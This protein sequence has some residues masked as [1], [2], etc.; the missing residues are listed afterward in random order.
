MRGGCPKYRPEEV[1]KEPT[2]KVFSGR[3]KPRTYP[4]L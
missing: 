2:I 4:S 1:D 3:A